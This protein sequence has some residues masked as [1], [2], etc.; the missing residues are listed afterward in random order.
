[1]HAMCAHTYIQ[2]FRDLNGLCTFSKVSYLKSGKGEVQIQFC[3]K[4]ESHSLSHCSI[5]RVCQFLTHF[6]YESRSMHY[7]ALCTMYGIPSPITF[8]GMQ[9]FR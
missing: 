6:F 3:L 4:L 5:F 7:L 1:M 8:I 9:G 2:S